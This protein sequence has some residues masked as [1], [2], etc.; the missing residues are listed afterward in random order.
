MLFFVRPRPVTCWMMKLRVRQSVSQFSQNDPDRSRSSGPVSARET[1]RASGHRMAPGL[2]L[3]LRAT[4]VSHS[5]LVSLAFQPENPNRWLAVSCGV[6]YDHPNCIITTCAGVLMFRLDKKTDRISMVQVDLVRLAKRL[7]AHQN[8][9]R[10]KCAHLNRLCI[11]FVHI[12]P[13]N[14]NLNRLGVLPSQRLR[15][16]G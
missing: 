7:F 15:I 12:D 9:W 11:V 16:F 14:V 6:L 13:R 10:S 8:S 1:G 4:A 5:L 2:F 3:Q